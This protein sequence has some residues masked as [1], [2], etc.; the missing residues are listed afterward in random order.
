MFNKILQI[1]NN[2][3]YIF[4]HYCCKTG[5]KCL[6]FNTSNTT[7]LKRYLKNIYIIFFISKW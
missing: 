3:I 7:W 6:K 5:M 1:Q 4:D 2:F